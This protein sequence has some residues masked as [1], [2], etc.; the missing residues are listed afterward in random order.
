MREDIISFIE[1]GDAPFSIQMMGISYCDGNYLIRR[2]ESPIYCFEY[3][4]EGK[5]TVMHG[6]KVF[7]PS[8]GD[9]YILHKGV[10]HVY[11]SDRE[12]PWTKIW[13]NIYGPIVDA[14]MSAYELHEVRH[15]QGLDIRSLFYKILECD[16]KTHNQKEIFNSASLIFHELLQSIH[17]Y[18]QPSQGNDLASTIKDLIDR[19]IDNNVSLE[20]IAKEAF[21]SP[22][23]AIRIFK[24]RYNITPYEYMMERRVVV[25]KQ[26]LKNTSIPIKEI[27]YRLSFRDQH[28]FSAFFKRRTGISPLVFRKK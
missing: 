13:F 1:D 2:P 12:Y 17:D 21:C 3:I 8:K 9:I 19:N 14:L 22:A 4:L 15:I 10:D 5:G 26:L 18:V 27:A 25:A 23:H 20:Y 11:Y 28:Y 24:E 7:Y 6:S 16:R